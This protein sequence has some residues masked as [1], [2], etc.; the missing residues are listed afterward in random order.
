MPL[1]NFAAREINYKIVYY[2]CGLC[3]KTTNIQYIHR[4]V[5]P[6]TR[7]KLVSIATE[8]ERTLYFDFLPLSLGS[9]K[10]MKTRFHL[11]TVPGQSHYNASRKLV[12]QGVDGIVFV[13][14]SQISRLDENVESYLNLW[15]NLFEQGDDLSRMALVLQMNKR[16][17][18]EVFSVP[19]LVELLNQIR[20]PVFEASALTGIGVFE[21]L[22]AVC[23]QVIARTAQP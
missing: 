16:D 12:L 4:K 20:S 10:G 23:K 5:N 13:V 22:K 2:G 6:N 8:E 15:D 1:I 17:L 19:D 3:G 14:D 7:G 18:T 11:Y 21:T 9:V